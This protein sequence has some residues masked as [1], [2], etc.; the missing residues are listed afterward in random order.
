MLVVRGRRED[1]GEV[2]SSEVAEVSGTCHEKLNYTTCDMFEFYSLRQIQSYIY[3]IS[4][5]EGM[6]KYACS[7]W[8]TM[9]THRRRPPGDEG[10]LDDHVI[11]LDFVM[12][13]TARSRLRSSER[14]AGV[15]SAKNF[16]I[17]ICYYH[18]RVL[19]IKTNLMIYNMTY[20][21]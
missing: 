13:A 11:R 1:G 3:I 18:I 14:F 4:N 9:R 19:P 16:Q 5:E 20:K 12:C 2:A 7:L 17:F 6:Q 10:G 21:I 15:T 8:E